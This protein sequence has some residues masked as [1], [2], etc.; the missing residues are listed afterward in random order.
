MR[1][2]VIIFQLP[3]LCGRDN[4]GPAMAESEEPETV[5]EATGKDDTVQNSFAKKK[6]ETATRRN[7][8]K[9]TWVSKEDD[10]LD[11]LRA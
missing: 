4:T 5:S 3:N 10:L 7:V 11:L 6:K 1:D 2:N 8:V 9:R